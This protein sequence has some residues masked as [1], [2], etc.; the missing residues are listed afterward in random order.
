MKTHSLENPLDQMKKRVTDL[1]ESAHPRYDDPVHELAASEGKHR[2]ALHE[3]GIEEKFIPL[4]ADIFSTQELEKMELKKDTLFDSMTRVYNRNTFDNLC[5]KLVGI[6]KREEKDCSFLLI[7]FD[8][9]KQV[10]DQYGHPAGDEALKQL[11]NTIKK[12]I[13]ESDVLFRAGGEEFV[14]YMPDTDSAVAKNVAE[15][16]RKEVESRTIDIED[17]NGQKLNLQKTITIG[18][19]S[20]GQ[21]KNYNDGHGEKFDKA[22]VEKIY[23]L[24]DK[25]LYKGKKGGRNQVVVNEEKE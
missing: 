16:I 14:V 5:W 2:Q 12:S 6:E 18:C 22:L 23:A 8:Y 11:V 4:L 13:R 15:K 10:N 21:V 9:F 20:M 17:E 24:A 25:A 1:K 3:M 19:A 7:D